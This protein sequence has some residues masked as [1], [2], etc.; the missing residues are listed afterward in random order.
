MEKQLKN[1]QREQRPRRSPLEGRNRLSIRDRDPDYQYRYVNSNDPNDPTRV[2]DLLER[3]YE[4]VPKNKTGEVGDSQVDKPAAFGSA[5]EISV[6]QGLKAIV[7]RQRHD[8]YAED[9]AIKQREN[10]RF[11]SEAEKRADYGKVT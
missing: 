2:E 6:G 3:G 9:Q 7:M 5:G 10:D 11:E 8:W 4:I 1:P